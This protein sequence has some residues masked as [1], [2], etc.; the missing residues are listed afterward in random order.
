MR[1]RLRDFLIADSHFCANK[2]GSMVELS[3][4]ILNDVTGG[5]KDYDDD[6]SEG[7]RC[8][9]CSTLIKWQKGAKEYICTS[10][11]TPHDENGKKIKKK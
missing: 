5:K 11:G 6:L 2:G 4:D 7:F 10:C 3:M 1:N 9:G 8:K